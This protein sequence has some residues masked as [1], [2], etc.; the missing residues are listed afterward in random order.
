[1]V[2][3]LGRWRQRNS[4]SA[5]YIRTYRSRVERMQLAVAD[6]FATSANPAALLVENEIFEEIK[7]EEDESEA[8][9]V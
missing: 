3:L 1:M 5:E 8:G 2:D 7:C 9:V 6:I 4:T